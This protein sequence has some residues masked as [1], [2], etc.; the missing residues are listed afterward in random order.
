MRTI[1][2]N[3]GIIEYAYDPNQKLDWSVEVR[4]DMSHLSPEQ[5]QIAWKIIERHNDTPLLPQ[6]ELLNELSR[7]GFG[8]EI[9]RGV[10]LEPMTIKLKSKDANLE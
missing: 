3:K 5:Q 9:Q 10:G 2:N 6:W 1:I 8:G 7:N 4:F